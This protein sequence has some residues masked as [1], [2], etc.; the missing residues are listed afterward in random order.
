MTTLV[1]EG[2]VDFLLP[3]SQ[4]LVQSQVQTMAP[5]SMQMG[6]HLGPQ[7]SSSLALPFLRPRKSLE[8]G[9]WHLLSLL[10]KAFQFPRGQTDREIKSLQPGP[11]KGMEKVGPSSKDWP[12][13][14]AFPSG[15]ATDNQNKTRGNNYDLW[16]PY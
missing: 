9:V 13:L 10:K 6:P 12:M 3:H 11:M 7:C 5:N 1:V 16:R 2:M 4:H 8:K 14:G 15:R